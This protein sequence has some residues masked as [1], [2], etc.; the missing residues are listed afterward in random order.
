MTTDE[1][2]LNH[3]AMVRLKFLF[4]FCIITVNDFLHLCLSKLKVLSSARLSRV[5]FDVFTCELL[6]DVDDKSSKKLPMY[7]QVL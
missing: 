5:I 6:P 7:P 2:L 3:T 1:Q 4:C